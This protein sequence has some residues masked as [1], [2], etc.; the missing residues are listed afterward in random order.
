MYLPQTNSALSTASVATLDR[1]IGANLCACV[2]VQLSQT[3]AA[4][5]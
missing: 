1:I 3:A 2:S 5:G 4:A